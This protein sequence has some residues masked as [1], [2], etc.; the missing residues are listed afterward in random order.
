MHYVRLLFGS[1]LYI[2][3][4]PFVVARQALPREKRRV[5]VEYA[6]L[7]GFYAVVWLTVPHALLLHCWLIPFVPAGLMFNIRS[8]AAHGIGDT[9]D[10][11]LASRSINAGP[12]VAFLFRNENFHL[13]HHLFPE[14]PSYNL[15]T[16]HGLVF[17]RMPRAATAPSYAGFLAQFVRQSLRFDDSPI[18]VVSLQPPRPTDGEGD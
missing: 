15:K 18:G 10:P 9:S 11:F 16:L 14:V 8:L 5:L 6:T 2:V 12:I 17:H 7:F 13:E 3:L 4:I 1:F